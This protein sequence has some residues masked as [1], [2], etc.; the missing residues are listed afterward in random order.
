MF[1]RQTA[2]LSANGVFPLGSEIAPDGGHQGRKEAAELLALEE[3]SLGC[4]DTSN[5]FV[6][7]Q[8]LTEA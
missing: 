2:L 3:P 5:S 1:Y 4:K 6:R 7:L 8:L